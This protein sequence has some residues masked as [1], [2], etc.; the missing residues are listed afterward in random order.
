M[1][2]LGREAF[3]KCPFKEAKSLPQTRCLDFELN[4]FWLR[5]ASNF[6]WAKALFCG[7]LMDFMPV[8]INM[9]VT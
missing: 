8:D 2:A 3:A 7:S 4:V 6:G 9:A 5:L 1:T